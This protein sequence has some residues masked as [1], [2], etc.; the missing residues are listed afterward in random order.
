MSALAVSSPREFACPALESGDRM[1]AAE[2][3]WRYERRPDIKKAE[4]I[5]GVVYVASPVNTQKHGSPHFNLVGAFS[6]Y[7]HVTDGVIGSDNSTIK[8]DKSALGRGNEPQPDIALYWDSGHAGQTRLDADGWL[9]SAPDLVAEV[10]YSSR[11]YDLGDKKELYRRIG[12]REY[13]V[14]QVEEGRI[15]W[16]QL[17]DGQYVSLLPA[18]HG[19]IHSLVFPGLKLDVPALLSQVPAAK[20]PK[21]PT[22]RR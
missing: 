1:D 11:S 8:L 5:D 16:W 9:I 4:L 19:V 3:H 17:L 12:V 15:D 13:V 14:W 22:R 18:D 2:F 21:R 20:L 7:A 6:A 10:A